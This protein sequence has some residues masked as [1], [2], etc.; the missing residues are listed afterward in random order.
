M[1]RQMLLACRRLSSLPVPFLFPSQLYPLCS[2]LY[3]KCRTNLSLLAECPAPAFVHTLASGIGL[4]LSA[5]HTNAP[6][7]SQFLPAC[8]PGPYPI[9]QL[10]KTRAPAAWQT[11]IDSSSTVQ[12]L[13]AEC[14]VVGWPLVP[15]A[16]QDISA[17]LADKCGDMSLSYN[18]LSSDW[19]V[20][21]LLRCEAN[22]NS[23]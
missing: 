16:K 3:H 11:R 15:D 20:G 19:E 21:K 17:Y 10:I 1:A 9:R 13:Y 18:P 5:Q 23:M 8:T 12:R 2:V 22:C 6:L 4:F 14:T 7:L